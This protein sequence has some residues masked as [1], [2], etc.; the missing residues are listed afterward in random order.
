MTPRIKATL[1]FL[2]LLA[3]A[4]VCLAQAVPALPE[5]IDPYAFD[6]LSGQDT[7]GYDA[8]AYE[9]YGKGNW[10]EAAKYYL[11][12]LQTHREDITAWY[13]LSCCY[14][15]LNKPDL[16]A[17]YLM[18][19]Y[20]AGYTDMGHIKA[21]TDYDLV[22]ESDAFKAA[23]DSLGTWQQRKAYYEGETR[24]LAAEVMLPFK[25]HVPASYDPAKKYPLLIG[26]HGFGDQAQRF[27]R[28]WR[29]LENE[30][31]IFAVPEAPYPYSES[32]PGFS[33]EPVGLPFDSEDLNQAYSFVNDYILDLK[34][35][36]TSSYN[37]GDTWLLGFSQGAYFGYV[38]A[39]NDPTSYTGLVACGGGIIQEAMQELNYDAARELKII[40][41]H[42]TQDKVVPY[43]Q[44]L[45]ARKYLEE[46]GFKNLV[47]DSFEGA[48]S[49]SPSAIDALLD[50]LGKKD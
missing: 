24:Y 4:S 32:Q 6:P 17:K 28:L 45:D 40:I 50:L 39:L 22:R 31:I 47:F 13:N 36:I 43:Q 14:G 7:A 48:H 15:L 19:A 35:W 25:L 16:A 27:S 10:E 38:L 33:W 5:N 42:G 12:H 20:K 26:L 34:D 41:S 1:L 2:L 37:I 9:A 49:V 21:D 11:A 18:Q 29:Y 23:L 30:D 46:H 3:S 44:A 8:L